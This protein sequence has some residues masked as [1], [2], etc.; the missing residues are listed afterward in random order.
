MGIC[1]F[2]P[3]WKVSKTTKLKKRF[4]FYSPPAN[5]QLKKIHGYNYAKFFTN[6]SIETD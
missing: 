5:L 3:T 2:I 4:F 1:Y 6:Q